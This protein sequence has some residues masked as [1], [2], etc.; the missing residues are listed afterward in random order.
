[1]SMKGLIKNFSIILVITLFGCSGST[2][3]VDENTG[4]EEYD[5][6]EWGITFSDS[7]IN[8]SDS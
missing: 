8:F 7:I 1:M 6:V 3:F 5:Y 4:I 2:I